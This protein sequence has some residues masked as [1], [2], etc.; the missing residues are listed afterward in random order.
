MLDTEHVWRPSGFRFQT[1]TPTRHLYKSSD[2][3]RF[4]QIVTTPSPTAFCK[5]HPASKSP[6]SA[7]NRPTIG[8]NLFT[9][10]RRSAT[11][12]LTRRPAT[13]KRSALSQFGRPCPNHL[14]STCAK[15]AR[16]SRKSP[17]MPNCSTSSAGTILSLRDLR[18]P[19]D[20]ALKSQPLRY[21]Q[22]GQ[23]HGP[24]LLPRMRR[25]LF[26]TTSSPQPPKPP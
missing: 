7:R 20:F 11:R 17:T 21:M 13:R 26:T 23:P 4:F 2:S 8:Y 22:V 9:S 10:A 24:R 25:D 6:P 16:S 3:P 15:A 14:R 1:Q 12:K 5:Q 18:A 19:C